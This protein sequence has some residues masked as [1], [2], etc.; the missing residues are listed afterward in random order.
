MRQRR[1]EHQ[2]PRFQMALLST[3][4]LGQNTS[5]MMTLMTNQAYLIIFVLDERGAVDEVFP[6]L[7]MLHYFL[8]CI[9]KR[10]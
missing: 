10:L 5:A 9:T 2:G 8:Q 4:N 3:L 6:S 7:Q 1:N